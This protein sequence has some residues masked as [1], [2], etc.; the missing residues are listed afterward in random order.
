MLVKEH[1]CWDS[2]MMMIWQMLPRILYVDNKMLDERAVSI[3]RILQLQ[4]I[5]FRVMT[6]RT[7]YVT[8]NVWE[9]RSASIFKADHRRWRPQ[10]PRKR[11]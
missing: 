4:I 2:T 1:K 9:E 8:T 6:P 11:W 7:V 10:V 5:V 3:F